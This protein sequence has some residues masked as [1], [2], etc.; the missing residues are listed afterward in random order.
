[1][2][3]SLGLN[4][5]VTQTQMG[6]TESKKQSFNPKRKSVSWTV[7]L[8]KVRRISMESKE[9]WPPEF[10]S[11]GQFFHHRMDYLS[12]W[13]CGDSFGFVLYSRNT[14]LVS[15]CSQKLCRFPTGMKFQTVTSQEVGRISPPQKR[16]LCS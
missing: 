8:S 3:S 2:S 16:A 6:K 11:G 4:S 15:S 10:L 12:I 13:V 5:G 14:L 7:F 9:N 1:M